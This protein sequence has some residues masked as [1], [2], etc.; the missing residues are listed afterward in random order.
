MGVRQLC[1]HVAGLHVAPQRLAGQRVALAG[2]MRGLRERQLQH[3]RAA[4]VCNAAHDI[5]PPRRARHP[6]IVLRSSRMR[7]CAT[8]APPLA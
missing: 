8:S 4:V 2:H 1:A 6:H 3:E 7:A 5:Q